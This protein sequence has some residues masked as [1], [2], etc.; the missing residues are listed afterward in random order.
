MLLPIND[1]ELFST[2]SKA[3]T[4]TSTDKQGVK[5]FKMKLVLE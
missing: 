2:F 1:P 5:K 4:K 3:T